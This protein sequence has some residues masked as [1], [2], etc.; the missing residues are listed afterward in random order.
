MFIQVLYQ[1]IH[2]PY[3]VYTSSKQVHTGS[4]RLKTDLYSQS[5]P[6]NTQRT[7][8]EITNKSLKTS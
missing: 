6:Y 2:L 4:C 5:Y 8:A 1:T 7:E 3:K